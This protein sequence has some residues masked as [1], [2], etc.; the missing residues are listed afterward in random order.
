MVLVLDPLVLVEKVG[1]DDRENQ[2]R[3]VGKGVV[4][5]QPHKHLLIHGQI[6]QP[7]LVAVQDREVTSGDKVVKE[8]REV[9]VNI[10]GLKM[11][12]MVLTKVSHILM[13]GAKLHKIHGHIKFKETKEEAVQFKLL[14]LIHGS[15]KQLKHPK[16]LREDPVEIRRGSNRTTGT[17]NSHNICHR[18]PPYLPVLGPYLPSQQL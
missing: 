10:S 4:N 16:R 6:Y 13:F 9:K 15:N 14:M 11:E 2:V 12:D 1:E 8:V 7:L 3:E 5:S 18:M 17:S